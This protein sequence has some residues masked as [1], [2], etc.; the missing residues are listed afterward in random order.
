MEAA[1]AKRVPSEPE[2]PIQSGLREIGD[3]TEFAFRSATHLPGSTR[4][5]S[6]ALRQGAIMIRG[7]S[8]LMFVMN[9]FLGI[10]VTS[11]AFFVLRPLGAT[12]FVGFFSGYI[13][14]RQTAPDMFAVVFVAKVCAG[15]TAEIGAMRVQQE[16]DA[17]ESEAV[18]P[19]RY[20]V[21]TRVLGALIFVPVGAAIALIGQF[22]GDFLLGVVILH[23]VP[24][25]LLQRL[26][27][28]SQ[29]PVDQLYALI[30]M[31]C[32]SIP[33]VLVACFYGLRTGGG[34]AGVGRSV[35]KSLLINVPLLH[36]IAGILAMGY[37]GQ[38]L[39]IPIGG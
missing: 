27:W 4:Y 5:L 9:V 26:Q 33:C 10:T 37:Y 21:G 20:I 17:L 16:V 6:E 38:S 14:P 2:G 19:M 8:L 13:S 7:T 15:M 28:F 39:R 32:I 25:E 35:A 12:D 23:A 1:S 36:I 29:G 34:P 22:V 11:F 18:D 31:A 3:L 30:Q 24:S